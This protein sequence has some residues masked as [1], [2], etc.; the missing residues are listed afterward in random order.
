M[1]GVDV[2]INKQKQRYAY[3]IKIKSTF[4]YVFPNFDNAF[5]K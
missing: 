3:Q 2:Y 1:K 5:D 4:D